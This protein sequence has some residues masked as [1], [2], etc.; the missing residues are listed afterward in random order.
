[1]AVIAK[2]IKCDYMWFAVSA[3][4]IT[5]TVILFTIWFFDFGV[6]G[7]NCFRNFAV[8]IF[9]LRIVFYTADINMASFNTIGDSMVVVECV[10]K[11][12]VIQIFDVFEIFCRFVH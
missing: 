5:V 9:S 12:G 2:S 10:D 3:S 1:M 4:F 7:G 11:E 8:I 6:F